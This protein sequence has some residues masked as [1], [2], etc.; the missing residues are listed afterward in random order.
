MN[1]V[2]LAGLLIDGA[3]VLI[4][5]GKLI[6]AI[7][8]ERPSRVK[9]MSI[10]QSGGLPYESLA[11]CLEMGNITFKDIDHVGYFFQPWREFLSLSTL[12]IKRSLLS[13]PT[14][15]YYEVYYLNSLRRHLAV[16]RLMR[17][18]SGRNR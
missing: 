4:Q 13:L 16:E 15:A 7:E 11:R 9:H 14:V 6:A 10:V 17:A 12:R 1:I 2:G 3:S 5:D 8:E 18:Q